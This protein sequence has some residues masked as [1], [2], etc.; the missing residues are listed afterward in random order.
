MTLT[1]LAEA[2]GGRLTGA[3][4]S[5]TRLSTDTRTLQAGDAY[6]ALAGEHF[7]GNNFVAQ[8]RLAGAVAAIVS[9][10]NT[11]SL[12]QLVVDDTAVAYA[13]A[14]RLNR[15]RS[16]AQVVAL[17]GSQGK[18]TVKEMLA[19][20]FATYTS[21]LVTEANLNNTIGVPLTLLRLE[22][23]H[24]FAVIEMGANQPGEIAFSVAAAEPDIALIT[25]AS[26]THIE[27]FGSLEGIVQAKGE[28]IDGIKPNGTL[29]L[30]ADDAHLTQWQQRAANTLRVVTFSV[31]ATQA[32]NN[33]ADKATSA[34]SN[35]TDKATNTTSNAA[36][37]AT[38]KA[39]NVT[40]DTNGQMHFKLLTPNGECPIA[41][42]LMGRHNVANALAASAVALE[43]GVNLDAV[44]QGL[45]AVQAVK[46]RLQQRR[47]LAGSTILDD[48]YN[49]NP[50]AFRAAIDVLV[51]FPGRLILVAGDM[52]ELGAE[53][54]SS[55]THLGEYARQAGVNELWATGEESV[56]TVAGFG[57][58][59]KHFP[60]KN[61]LLEA[62][63]KAA[64]NENGKVVFLVKGSRGAQM[65]TI[66]TGLLENG[67][68]KT[69]KGEEQC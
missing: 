7:D 57:N 22:P 23:E 49:A 52:K 62:C 59:A 47:G 37:N 55:H 11:E 29:V 18:T 53:S 30:N 45:A 28:I 54:S 16:E 32:T 5:F 44:Q 65:E 36:A 25:N 24:R 67:K 12:P 69:S 20:I 35:T 51:K 63:R 6:L 46:G 34:T 33:T 56:N 2:T 66:V 26:P 64:I 60:N 1:Q 48:S 10:A 15:R 14:A 3:D 21:T 17:T 38:Y 9:R 27:G 58:T 68:V 8:A 39:I 40:T 4:I 50:E 42:K 43:A 13:T 61:A 19:A 31:E 41:L